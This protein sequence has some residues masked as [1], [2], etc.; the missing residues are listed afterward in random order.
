MSLDTLGFPDE[1]SRW[2]T[3]L[4]VPIFVQVSTLVAGNDV[5]SYVPAGVITLTS[6]RRLS[7]ESD[8]LSVFADGGPDIP[9]LRGVMEVL[10][11][12]G[13]ETLRPND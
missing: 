11:G 2:K 13:R 1:A 4:S 6:D 5:Q 7:G 8:E 3:F 12:M 9:T 10:I